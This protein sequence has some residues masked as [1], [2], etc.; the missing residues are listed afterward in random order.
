MHNISLF[1]KTQMS[2]A[3]NTTNLVRQYNVKIKI[4]THFVETVKLFYELYERDF[5]N[6]HGSIKHLCDCIEIKSL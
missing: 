6:T 1:Y 4:A 5:S 2:K 3:F